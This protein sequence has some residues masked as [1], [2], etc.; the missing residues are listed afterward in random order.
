[1]LKLTGVSFNT[2]YNEK[3]SSYHWIPLKDFTEVDKYG[4]VV[5]QDDIVYG[6]QS[7]V[8]NNHIYKN[9]YIPEY[10]CSEENTCTTIND[11]CPN[12]F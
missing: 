6:G 11:N 5:N 2:Y 10:T 12:K 9:T 4:S 3:A 1:M 7:Y 8:I